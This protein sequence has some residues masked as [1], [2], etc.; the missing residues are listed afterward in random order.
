ME[1]FF[2]C[3]AVFSFTVLLIVF[4]R[5]PAAAVG[6][7]DTPGGR[8]HHDGAIPL[9]GGLAMA[10]AFCGVS[11]LVDD[12]F[13]KYLFCYL[14]VI[15]VA[16]LGSIDDVK[17]IRAK[18]KLIWQIVAAA[19]MVLGGNIILVS[20]GNLTGMGDL[21]LGRLAVPFTIF[22]V[23]GLIN[24]INMSDGVDG[25]AGGQT[26]VS[27]LW[28][29]IIASMAGLRVQAFV[30]F[31]F[32]S[33]ILGFLAFN[34]RSPWRER[35][36]VFMG[37]AGS[38]MLGLCLSWFAIEVSQTPRAGVMPISVL[39]ILGL[40]VLDTVTLMVRRLQKGQSPFQAGRDHSHHILLH[41]GFSHG[42]TT[43]IMVTFSS[44]LGAVGFWGWWMSAPE[45]LMTCGYFFI[46]SVYFWGMRHAWRVSHFFAKIVPTAKI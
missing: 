44:I 14:S 3:L 25:L 21:G 46:F 24:A 28:L 27:S 23:V 35:A 31:L 22:A 15:A 19:V 45:W 39:W 40:P 10:V 17:D 2:Y 1:Q 20:F 16:I 30:I 33:V 5:G 37:D 11:L 29:G 36:T 12:L 38:M 8:K 7:V 13:R 43:A 9:I 41:A 34:A 4:L 18:I 26:A 32:L 6:L 42:Q